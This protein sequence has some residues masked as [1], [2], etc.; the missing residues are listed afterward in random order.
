MADRAESEN[1]GSPAET[2]TGPARLLFISYASHD[3][4]VAQKVCSALEAA[5]FPCWMAPRDVTPGA[6]YAD[7][8]VRAINE[9]QAVVLVLSASAVASSHVGREVE[10]AASKHKPII[11]FRIDAAPL[12]P[13][14][15]Y[16][17][18]ESQWIDVVKLG[19]Q[20]G[21][22]KLA[23]AVGSAPRHPLDAIA[24]AKLV[25]RGGGR[26][27]LIA[28]AAAVVGVGMA[29]GLGLHFWTSI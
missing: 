25:E 12:A 18:S 20:T 21:L 29:I 14:L 22:A 4:E 9:A 11:A 24:P 16:F 23:E 7:A 1:P 8:I 19:M 17:L 2:T 5:G 6:Q 27:K 28:A 3:A 15:E 26:R 13:A 10:R